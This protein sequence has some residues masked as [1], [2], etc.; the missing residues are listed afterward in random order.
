MPFPKSN[1]NT[2]VTS[3]TTNNSQQIAASTIGF[4]TNFPTIGNFWG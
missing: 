4:G 1:G 2:Q 3:R